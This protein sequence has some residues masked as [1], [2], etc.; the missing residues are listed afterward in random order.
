[1]TGPAAAILSILTIAAMALG[2]G[3]IYLL[4]KRRGATKGV[5]MLLAAAVMLGNVMIWTL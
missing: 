4:V 1:M 5:L 3:G 2:A